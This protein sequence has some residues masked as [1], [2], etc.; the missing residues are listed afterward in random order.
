[1]SNRIIRNTIFNLPEGGGQGSWSSYWETLISAVVE[2]ANPDEIILTFPSAKSLL[3]SDFTISGVSGGITVDS[4]SWAGAVLTLKLS[5]DIDASDSPVVAFKIANTKAVTNNTWYPYDVTITSISGGNRISFTQGDA[6][7][8][9]E[10]SAS[11]DGAAYAVIARLAAG[12]T[13]YD[14]T[15][16]YAN[17][18]DYKLRGIR[19]NVT[20]DSDAVALFNR[21]GVSAY[22]EYPDETRKAIINTVFATGKTKAFWAKMDAIWLLAGHG[23]NSS[24]LNILANDHNIKVTNS[25][26]FEI[27]RGWTFTSVGAKY[28]N[29]DFTLPGDAVNFTLNAGSLGC[30]PRTNNSSGG[31]LIGIGT[32]GS[33]TYLQFFSGNIYGAI[34]SAN[35]NSKTSVDPRTLLIARRSNNTTS[36]IFNGKTKTEATKNVGTMPSGEIVIGFNGTNQFAFAFIG[37]G[38][39]DTDVSDM[40]DLFVDGYLNSIGAKI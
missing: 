9:T 18:V 32:A 20:Y 37:G 39:D 26:V 14:H 7:S 31:A 5:G 35:Y 19:D 29:T 38:I 33:N 15:G 1:M 24:K 10:I 3:A 27:D 23:S 4:I 2:D 25:P 34:N 28:G 22:G 30:Y 6:T 13:T 36:A 17:I 16:L 40:Y 12:Q 8:Q 21:M 11:I